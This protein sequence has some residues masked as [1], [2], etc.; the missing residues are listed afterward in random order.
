MPYVK[1]EVREYIEPKLEEVL[2]LST[3]IDDGTL[4]YILTRVILS[5]LGKQPNYDRIA[6]GV[7]ALEMAKLELYR[8]VAAPYEDWKSDEN[9]DVY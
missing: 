4:N 5:Y 8:R 6:D 7:K 9:G 1:P 2:M 3:H